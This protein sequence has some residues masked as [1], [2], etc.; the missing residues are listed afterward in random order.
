ML[1]SSLA[2]VSKAKDSSAIA[3]NNFEGLKEGD[4]PYVNFII[5]VT[6]GAVSDPKVIATSVQQRIQT[7]ALKAST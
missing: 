6:D 3:S 5:E 7:D 4:K 2:P 1:L